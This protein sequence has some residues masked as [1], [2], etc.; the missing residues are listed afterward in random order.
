MDN[1]LEIKS[2]MWPKHG[3]E[4][5]QYCPICGFN[6]R[7]IM[8][9]GLIDYFF[10]CA[11]GEWSLYECASC[12]SAYLDPRPTKQT[13]GLAYDNYYTHEATS[14][15]T[16]RHPSKLRRLIRRI[17]NGYLNA[18]FNCKRSDAS[19]MGS[20]L[21]PVIKPLKSFLQAEARHLPKLPENGG[22][23]LDIGCGNGDFI[24]L[25]CEAG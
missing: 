15:G 12:E 7:K 24:Q 20:V 19:G 13:I 21:V 4:K 11:P 9:K 25:A 17:S 23:L 16:S 8:Y 1:F 10:E 18:A 6:E 3:L 5:V 14:P 22:T 2:R